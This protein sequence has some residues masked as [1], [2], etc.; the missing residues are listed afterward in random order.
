MRVNFPYFWL[1]TYYPLGTHV[2]CCKADHKQVLYFQR[3]FLQKLLYAGTLLSR[4]PQQPV[5]CESTLLLNLIEG[6]LK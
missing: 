4:R 1:K 6:P 5:K 3:A 2:M